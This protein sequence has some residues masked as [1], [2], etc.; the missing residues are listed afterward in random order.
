MSK[1]GWES[2]DA[3]SIWFSLFNLTLQNCQCEPIY[4]GWLCRHC[5]GGLLGHEFKSLFI[6]LQSTTD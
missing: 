6:V 5:L 1:Q 2:S 3:G 4:L